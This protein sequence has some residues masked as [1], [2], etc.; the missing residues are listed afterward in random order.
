MTLRVGFRLRRTTPRPRGRP[1]RGARAEIEL[2]GRRW[3]SRGEVDRPGSD[4]TP[5]RADG[6][7]PELPEPTDARGSRS[8]ERERQGCTPSP[9]GHRCQGSDWAAGGGSA[10]RL[11]RRRGGESREGERAGRLKQDGREEK[12][13]INKREWRRGQRCERTTE[14]GWVPGSHGTEED[15]RRPGRRRAAGGVL[16]LRSTLEPKE[17]TTVDGDDR[18]WAGHRV[19]CVPARRG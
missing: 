11:R 7:E 14:P 19:L 16:P 5:T 13:T 6:S 1:V 8:E 3:S 9:H 2:E 15:P 10:R 18:V 4:P 17:R 12:K